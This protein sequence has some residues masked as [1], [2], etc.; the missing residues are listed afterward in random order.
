[1][2]NTVVAPTSAHNRDELASLITQA[3]ASDEADQRL[4]I[5][6]ALKHYKKAVF[7]ATILSTSLVM[8][9]YDLV[10]VSL[11]ADPRTL[12]TLVEILTVSN[13]ST[14]STDWIS[15][16]DASVRQCPTSPASIRSL[17]HGNLVSPIRRS[18]D[19]SSAF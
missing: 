7:W 9:G 12:R 18:L 17:P 3:K 10:I 8:E 11:L 2:A 16:S 19:N 6:E 1:M 15:S 4:T 14:P 5:R 13:R